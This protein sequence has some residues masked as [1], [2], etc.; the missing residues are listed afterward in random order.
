M[1]PQGWPRSHKEGPGQN[2]ESFK[3]SNLDLESQPMETNVFLA[4]TVL[5]TVSKESTFVLMPK[6]EK[7]LSV[8]AVLDVEFVLL[9]VLVEF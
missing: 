2:R 1:P 4:V 5:P 7:T 6:K 8:Q 3:D 9:Y